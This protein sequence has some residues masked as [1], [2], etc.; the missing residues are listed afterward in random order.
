M[1]I[2]YANKNGLDVRQREPM[3]SGSVKVYK[4]H[5][6]FDSYWDGFD[7]VAVFSAGDVRIDV[8]LDETGTCFIPWEVLSTPNLEVIVGVYGVNDDRVLPTVWGSMGTIERGVILGGEGIPEPTPDIYAQLMESL[9]NKADTLRLFSPKMR[10]AQRLQLLSGETVLSEVELGSMGGGGTMDHNSLENRDAA[11]QH[12]IYAITGLQTKL[13]QK[14]DGMAL[15]GLRL[16]LMTGSEESSFVMLPAQKEYSLGLDAQHLSLKADGVESSAVTLPAPGTTDH[17]QLQNRSLSDQHPIDSITGLA[18]A[19]NAKGD[20]LGVD[21]KELSLKRGNVVL[22][23]IT[24]PESGV[25]FTTDETLTL[26]EKVLSVTHPIKFATRAEFDALSADDKQGV[27][28]VV[29]NGIQAGRS[30][31]ASEEVQWVDTLPIGT[32]IVS[33][34]N[35]RPSPDWELSGTMLHLS[36]GANIETDHPDFISW[37][38]EKTQ[39]QGPWGYNDTTSLWWRMPSINLVRGIDANGIF[40]EEYP[41]EQNPAMGAIPNAEFDSSGEPASSDAMVIKKNGNESDLI[42]GV[43]IEPTPLFFWI[44]VEKPKAMS[45]GASSSSARYELYWNGELVGGKA[46][47]TNWSDIE[48]KPELV[49]KTDLIPW[50]KIENKP[51]LALKSDLASVYR[52]KGSVQTFND[53]PTTGNVVGDVWNVEATNMN[54]GWTKDGLWDPLGQVFQI[55][56]ITNDEIDEITGRATWGQN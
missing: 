43:A 2:I 28:Y 14:P 16:S 47:P 7:R 10:M 13:D 52:Y 27:L 42:S 48:G 6:E 9:K 29:D 30:R 44:H 45:A 3:T 38:Y 17:S 21:G 34:N 51:D 8:A 24:L 5:F 20:S 4:A 37:V 56:P 36:N 25:Q 49:T 31:A 11:D 1:F 41:Y 26:M 35:E 40:P 32:I 55:D 15:T 50:D 39:N 53:L 33:L 23:S 19:L 46:G 54:Y 18:D 12:P 22:S